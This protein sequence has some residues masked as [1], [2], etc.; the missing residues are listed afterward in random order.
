MPRCSKAGQDLHAKI[1]RVIDR[2]Y[3]R[4]TEGLDTRDLQEVNS[5]WG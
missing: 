1:S 2:V 5:L 4:F 3:D